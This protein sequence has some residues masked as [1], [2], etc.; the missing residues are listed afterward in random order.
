MMAQSQIRTLG[1]VLYENFELL[2][3]Y[4]YLTL[5]DRSKKGVASPT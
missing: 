1:T 4:Y 5:R 2:D 3:V